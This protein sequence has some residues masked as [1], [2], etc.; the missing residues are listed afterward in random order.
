MTLKRNN[1]VTNTIRNNQKILCKNRLFKDLTKFVLWILNNTKGWDMQLN[2]FHIYQ[3]TCN[4]AF[5]C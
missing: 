1:K 5:L 2:V 4:F 3:K